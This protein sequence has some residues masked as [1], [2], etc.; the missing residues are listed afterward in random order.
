MW[1]FPVG[2][3]PPEPAVRRRWA[4]RDRICEGLDLKPES[5]FLA[6]NEGLVDAVVTETEEPDSVSNAGGDA[7]RLAMNKLHRLVT[8]PSV[9][10]EAILFTA[11][12]V[13]RK[14]VPRSPAECLMPG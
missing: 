9:V 2:N 14:V 6:G 11:N 13:K 4:R 5:G 1:I 12:S 10:M 8:T 3:M 7:G